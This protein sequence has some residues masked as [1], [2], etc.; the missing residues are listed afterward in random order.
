MIYESWPWRRELT[1]T[2]NRIT[3][4]LNF[5]YIRSDTFDLLERDIF[6]GFFSVRKLIEAGAKIEKRVAEMQIPVER[7]KALRPMGS[8][9]RFEFYD[10]FDLDRPYL[11]QTSVSYL[12]NQMMHSL[13][14]SFGSIRDDASL[15]IFFVSD[16]DRLKFCNFVDLAT[17]STIF[18]EVASSHA[19]HITL[20][21]LSGG[22]RS[23]IATQ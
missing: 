20:S 11:V 7:C 23:L 5:K 9:E 10:Y 3:Q 19:K 1:R 8:Y 4:V 12:A 13:L 17:V 16:K 2:A 6:I 22:G 14:F 15:G 21:S 18:S